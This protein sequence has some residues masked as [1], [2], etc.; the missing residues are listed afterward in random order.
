ME[1][2]IISRIG[3]KDI[4][5]KQINLNDLISKIELEP[6][7]EFLVALNKFEY[8][9]HEEGISEL[10][11]ICNDWLHDSSLSF[12]KEIINHYSQF[13]QVNKKHRNIV[14]DLQSVKIINKVATLRVIEILLANGNSNS[15]GNSDPED[16]FK[17]YL[18]I[19]DELAERE[20]YF[21]KK[22]LPQQDKKENEIRLHLYLG[23]NQMI[24][25]DE[26]LNKK[27]WVEAL[28]F[29]QFEKWIKNQDKYNHLTIDYLN[30]FEANDWYELFTIIFEINTVGLNHYK[31][32]NAENSK[33]LKLLSYFSDHIE[34]NTNWNELSEI[35]KKPLYKQKNGDFLI[36]DFA[37]LLE[38]FFS[39]IYHDIINFSNE[40]NLQRFHQ[41]YSLTFVEGY[42]LVN[43]LKAVF[44]NSYIQFDEKK[45]KSIG[46]K[47]IDNLALPDYYIRNGNKV[48]LFEC[49]N[50][51]ISNR[52]KL[53]I[54]CDE[55]EI[56]LKDKFYV[57]G[58]KK[59]AVKQ[60]IN[61][62]E[63]S[64]NGKYKSFDKNS[65]LENCIYYPI[66]ITTD[67]TLTSLAFNEILNE[68]LNKDL[69]SSKNEFSKRIKPL[70]IIHIN[71]L[72]LRTSRLKK[73]DQFIDDYS[74]YCKSNKGVD[75]MIS[76]SDYLDRIKFLN[77][78]YIDHKSFKKMLSGS[79]LPEK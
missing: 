41:D 62:I 4:F 48:F 18:V 57:S 8:K 74:K 44:G 25:N 50:S 31:F 9:I 36:L 59:K 65:K 68:Y 29:A 75:G 16:L 67:I 11:F 78:R 55:I 28:K 32:S 51:L 45:I 73:L 70:T 43:S 40:K 56:E 17:L 26:S 64:Q 39:G 54:N 10:K 23:I 72:L 38:K 61:F 7:L 46:I 5:N 1:T 6:A 49:K 63:L 24:L 77:D 22:W 47:G 35:R 33:N 19:N 60:L 71:D 2:K 13:L 79:I 20:S 69:V 58:T 37:F 12:K 30:Q 21:F 14:V 34:K 15:G 3:Y 53:S 27:I 42:L 66:L 52:S 76:F